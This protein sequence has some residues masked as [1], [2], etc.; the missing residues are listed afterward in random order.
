MDNIIIYNT[1]DGKSNVKLY[2]SNGTVWLSQKAMSELFNCSVDNI[3]LH[4]KHI[5]SD[6]E[7]DRDSV[8]E[9]SSITASDGKHYE[10]CEALRFEQRKLKKA[11]QIAANM[12]CKYTG[13]KYNERKI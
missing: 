7:L 4:L 13:C 12:C 10:V 5:F 9:E 6:K 11:A 8:T 3:S 2:A 1:D